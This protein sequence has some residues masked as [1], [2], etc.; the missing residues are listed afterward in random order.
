MPMTL[1]FFLLCFSYTSWRK[2]K[3]EFKLFATLN[4]SMPLF[5]DKVKPH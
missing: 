2:K 3:K 5:S 4:T 1:L